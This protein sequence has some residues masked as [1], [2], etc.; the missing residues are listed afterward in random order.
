M[1]K[2]R[3]NATI[4]YSGG[5]IRPTSHG[6]FRAEINAAA[7]RTRKTFKSEA[8]ARAWIDSTLA[9]LDPG[10]A[11]LD[12]FQLRQ[13]RQALALLPAGADL[14]H[15][16]RE[17]LDAHQVRRKPLADAIEDYLAEKR[18]A[19]LRSKSIQSAQPLLR[20]LAPTLGQR[21]TGDITPVDLLAWLDQNKKSGPT[22][23]NYRRNWHGFFAWC[24]RMGYCKSNPAAAIT[25][26]R[27]E[28][29]PPAIFTP[30]QTWRILHAAEAL[31]PALVPY[32][33]V[34]FF[35][36][37]RPTELARL[38]RAAIA[39]G[40]IRIGA[41]V[42]KVRSQRYITIA[43]NLAAWL[44]AYPGKG[45]LLTMARKAFRQAR[46]SIMAKAGI[47]RWPPDVMRHSFATYHLAAHHDAARTAEQLGHDTPSTLYDHYRALATEAQGRRYFEIMSKKRPTKK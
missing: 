45:P 44:K 2:R 9:E 7:R 8:R 18:S 47:T 6:T 11:P 46:Q 29:Q 40:H 4:Y 16:V 28:R 30:R 38:D 3:P 26:V 19:G 35:A 33:A 27:R 25:T 42:S 15:V 32:F 13:A 37:V 24:Q 5:I 14:A 34:G 41:E 12:A 17:W 23:N 21:N 22:R 20:A 43:P 36:G 39:H 10:A 31:H 1:S